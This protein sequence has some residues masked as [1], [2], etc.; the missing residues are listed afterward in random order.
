MHHRP[1]AHRVAVPDGKGRTRQ[2]ADRDA[3]LP[4][5]PVRQAA[6]EEVGDRPRGRIVLPAPGEGRRRR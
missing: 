5:R 1:H 4:R 3:D 6:G 2:V